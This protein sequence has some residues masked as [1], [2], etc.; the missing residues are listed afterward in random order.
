MVHQHELSWEQKQA[1][2]WAAA[3]G[4]EAGAV[5]LGGNSSADGKAAD[6][7]KERTGGDLVG[8]AVHAAIPTAATFAAMFRAMD[9]IDKSRVPGLLACVFL[10]TIWLC[11]HS[12]QVR[13]PRAP[14]RARPLRLDVSACARCPCAWS[15]A[16]SARA[17]RPPHVPSASS[18]R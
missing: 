11:Q 13:R 14:P 12:N 16:A 2:Y 4:R 10:A 8:G 9:R 6:D 1:N 17:A 3:V 7:A 5:E 15:A 18:R